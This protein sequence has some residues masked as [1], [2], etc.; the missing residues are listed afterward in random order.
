[1]KNCDN[2]EKNY[3]QEVSPLQIIESLH[4]SSGEFK[5]HLIQIPTGF[6][7]L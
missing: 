3:F 5:D 2:T 1:M 6:P 7:V 4:S